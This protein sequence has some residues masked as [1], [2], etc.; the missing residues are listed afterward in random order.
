MIVT[1]DISVVF[2]SYYTD[3]YGKTTKLKYVRHNKPTILPNISGGPP[4]DRLHEVYKPI[5]SDADCT[6]ALGIFGYNET[7]MLCAGNLA[8]GGV[9][10]CSVSVLCLRNK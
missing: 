2:S 4:V 10:A 1:S 6:S 3:S 9:D 5:L 7:S 8:Q